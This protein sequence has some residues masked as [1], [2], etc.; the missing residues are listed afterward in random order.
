[1][2]IQNSDISLE[3]FIDFKLKLDPGLFWK[4]GVL[5]VYEENKMAFKNFFFKWKHWSCVLNR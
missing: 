5:F 2:D 3:Y 1:M 4:I